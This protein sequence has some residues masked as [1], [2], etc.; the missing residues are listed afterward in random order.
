MSVDIETFSSIDLRTSGVFSYTEAD[1]FE[2]LLFGYSFGN[3]PIKVIDLA[4]GEKIPID[5]IEALTDPSIIKT[6]FNAAFE[7]TCISKHFKKEIP[8]EQWRCSMVHS[9]TLGLPGNLAGAAKALRLEVQK[10]D[11]GKGLIRYFS[12]PCKATKANGG[13]TRNLPKHDTERWNLFK[14]YCKQDKAVEFRPK[15]K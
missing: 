13:R 2:I 3:E 1:D 8:P 10:M 4:S 11:E 14:R 7:R 15:N 6:A 9:L 5:V 12:I